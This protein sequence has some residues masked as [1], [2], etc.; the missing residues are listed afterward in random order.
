MSA[1]TP[2]RAAAGGHRPGMRKKTVLWAAVGAGLLLLAAANGHLVYVA[3]TSQPDCVAH[4][5]LGDVRLG[6]V[7]PGP[8]D[9]PRGQFGAATSSCT[10]R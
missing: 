10:P 6:D 3:F 2:G 8:G 1:V 7:Q 9:A 4:V 5:R